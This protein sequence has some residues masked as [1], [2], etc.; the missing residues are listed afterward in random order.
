MKRTP[1]RALR[2]CLAWV[3]AVLCGVLS[4]TVANA[5]PGFFAGKDSAERISRSTQVVIMNR[6]DVSVVSVMTDYDGPNQPFALVMP[7]PKDV[8]LGSV[9]T[10]K[11]A[12]VERIDELTA[13]RF[14]EY[15]EKNPCEPGKAEQIWE[16][17]MV[18]S[19]E[20]DF[21]G[22]GEMFKGGS[23]APPEMREVMDPDFR[24]DG[25]EYTFTLVPGD[26][27][28]WLAAKGYQPPAGVAVD[29]Y[30]D[31]AFLVAIVDPA[32]V[33]LGKKGEALLSPI[34]YTTRQPVKVASTLGK[35]HMKGFQELIIYTI[36]PKQRFEVA[37][38]PNRVPPT[39][40][41]VEF[42]VKERVGEYYAALHDML[43]AKDKKAFL[44]EYSWDTKTCGEPCPN[45]KLALH[46]RLTLGADAFEAV[47][48]PDVQ[49]PPPPERTPEEEEVYKK[50]K[51]DEKKQMDEL[52]LEVARRKGVIARQDN[53]VLTRLHHRYDNEG[54]PSD[55][56]LKPAPPIQGGVG[57]PAGVDG[58]L[59]QGAKEAAT[60]TLQTR[61][62][63]LHP[64][65]SVL[66][67]PN[68]E[69]YRWGKP[70][71]S[72]RGARKIWVADQLA[73]RDRKQQKPL[74]ATRTAVAELGIPGKPTKAQQA[75][76]A[77]AAPTEEKKDGCSVS[78]VGNGALGGGLAR[79]GVFVAL[80]LGA[81]V[82]LR[83][84]AR[85]HG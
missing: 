64:D 59:P 69:R 75:A 14:H 58:E 23:K 78:A 83:R 72:Y 2:A 84:R 48:P 52:A 65:I 61:F 74:E 30:Q 33:E 76:A 47:L 17:S 20:T 19:S 80:L 51:K 32:K 37:N 68:P 7:V 27:K 6:D 3:P 29:A 66:Q 82:G 54:L 15:W 57:T 12:S 81:A 60:N 8:V 31:M 5:L 38:Y 70:P 63:N 28:G 50:A 73:S 9:K 43:L 77:A 55:V 4:P 67:C 18:A 44:T 41:Q 11:R 36:N 35:V 13:P 62:V 46:E 16:Q 49:N 45:A 24:V 53:F 85:P 39:N 25:S 71:L 26:I 42:E 21:M 1:F 10:L 40:L 34:R 22:A 56:E 79:G